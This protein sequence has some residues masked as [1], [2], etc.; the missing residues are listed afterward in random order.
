V[1][2]V[3]VFLDR[4]GEPVRTA[5][6]DFLARRIAAPGVDRELDDAFGGQDLIIVQ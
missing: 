5:S 2:I 6:G 3:Q 4:H 1:E